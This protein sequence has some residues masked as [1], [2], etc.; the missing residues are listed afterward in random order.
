M[1]TGRSGMEEMKR[2]RRSVYEM[3]LKWYELAKDG[4]EVERYVR[5]VQGQECMRKFCRMRTD[6][7]GL[8]EDKKQYSNERCVICNNTIGE[9]VVHFLVVCGE[10]ER[11]RHVML[12]D[13]SGIVGSGEWLDEFWIVD[14]ERKM[15]LLLGKWL[16]GICNRVMVDVESV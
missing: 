8:L 16:E 9:D 1:A 2:L 3:Q 14:V 15:A 13:V 5:L 12:E 10:F 7:A 11:D 6:S 4:T